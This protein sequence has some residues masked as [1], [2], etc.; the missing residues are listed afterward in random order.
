MIN[1]AATE[2]HDID[3]QLHTSVTLA[4][5]IGLRRR[6]LPP[7]VECIVVDHGRYWEK[8][9]QIGNL[10]KKPEVKKNML[11]GVL[12]FALHVYNKYT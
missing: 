6:K 2:Y 11:T 10:T 12:Y 8:R 5:T 7:T 4:Q 1:A 9:Y 3:G